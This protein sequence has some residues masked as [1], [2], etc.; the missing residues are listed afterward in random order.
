MVRVMVFNATFNIISVILWWSVLLV[1][2]TEVPGENQWPVAS[3]W[4]TLSHNVV[5]SSPRHE[6]GSN[7]RLQVVIGTYFIGTCSC[8][9]NY[10]YMYHTT[11]TAQLQ[12][13][14]SFQEY[15]KIKIKAYLL[16][17]YIHTSELLGRETSKQIFLS[18][19]YCKQ[20]V[21]FVVIHWQ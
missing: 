20:I 18:M 3:H 9:S 12:K 15:L 4:Q 17:M 7:S 6:W 21:G 14:V 13:C 5:S 11:T 19:A 16:Y 8:K 1:E 2:E 10:M